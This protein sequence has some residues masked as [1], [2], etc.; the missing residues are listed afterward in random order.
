MHRPATL[1]AAAEADVAEQATWI[2]ADDPGA[3]VRF[4]DAVA[5]TIRFA[6]ENPAAGGRSP[7]WWRGDT[8]NSADC[9]KGL[10]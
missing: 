7:V 4:I 6:E 5:A 1:T 8:A 9:E 10:P 3:A 2:A